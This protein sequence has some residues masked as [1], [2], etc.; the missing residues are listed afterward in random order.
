MEDVPDDEKKNITSELELL[1]RLDHPNIVKMLDSVR[2]DDSLYIVLEFVENGSLLTILKRFGTV[3]EAL[4][5][6]YIRQVGV[7]SVCVCV[8]IAVFAS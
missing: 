8:C 6:R 7:S 5:A 4:I 3:P 2:T 1:A